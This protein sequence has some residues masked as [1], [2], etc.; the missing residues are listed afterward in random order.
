[1]ALNPTR[2]AGSLINSSLFWG[3]HI[4]L[5]DTEHIYNGKN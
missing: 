4:I 1:M 3:R 2:E 5:M